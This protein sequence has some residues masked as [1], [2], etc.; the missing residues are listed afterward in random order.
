MIVDVV[1]RTDEWNNALS[2]QAA[3]AETPKADN[4][5]LCST[6]RLPRL[7]IL[8]NRTCCRRFTMVLSCF[9]FDID[10]VLESHRRRH[11]REWIPYQRDGNSAGCMGKSRYAAYMSLL[12]L[13]P[14][15]I[16]SP[17]LVVWIRWASWTM[18]IYSG[19]CYVSAI[20]CRKKKITN[21]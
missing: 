21:R 18:D 15:S 8:I 3:L 6:S 19:R 16:R 14:R 20:A 13:H 10:L 4:K 5:G 11:G 17:W 7:H 9:A 2:T 12:I 1:W